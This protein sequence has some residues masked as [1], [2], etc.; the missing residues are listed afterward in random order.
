[1]ATTT[2]KPSIHH[3]QEVNVGKWAT[4]RRFEVKTPSLDYSFLGS[5]ASISIDREFARSK[6][7]YWLKTKGGNE[8]QNFGKPISGIFRYK[9][10][11]YFYGD[12]PRY[13][14]GKRK[15]QDLLIFFIP[16]DSREILVYY[17]PRFD[18]FTT[19][20]NWD[21]DRNKVLMKLSGK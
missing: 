10:T 16:P 2:P 4:T 3:L 20:A 8:G 13:I 21:K 19:Q 18:Q 6:P 1:M 12:R 14:N 7:D 11:H 15:K 5:V 9:D 17:Y